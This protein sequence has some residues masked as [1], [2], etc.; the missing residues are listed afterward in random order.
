MWRTHR[1]IDGVSSTIERKVVTNY[2]YVTKDML[3]HILLKILH[4]GKEHAMLRTH[5]RSS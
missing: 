2:E 3:K 5:F 4:A 1:K